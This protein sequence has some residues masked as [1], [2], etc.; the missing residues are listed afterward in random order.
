MGHIVKGVLYQMKNADMKVIAIIL[1]IALLFTLFT[2]NAVS[3]ASVVMLFIGGGTTATDGVA[4]EGTDGIGTSNTGSTVTSNT[5]ST[6]TSNTGSTVTSNT[7]STATN[8]T[9]STATD[10]GGSGSAQQGTDANQGAQQG[11]DAN[12]PVIA[13]PFAF[14]SKAAND[15]HT[16]GIA[17]YNKI[18]W[19]T[20]L[21]IEGLGILDSVIVPILESFMTTEDE[22][23][24]K[25][26]PKG[27]EDAMNRMPASNA[28]AQWIKSATAQKNG[29]N[30][31]VTVVLADAT[32]PSYADT[33]GYPLMTREFLDYK[34]VEKE[35]ANISIVKSLE[36]EI[37]Y[38]D[39]TITAEMTAD[40]KFISITHWGIGYMKA[41]LNG[42]INANGEL[43]FNAKYTDFQ[44]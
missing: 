19:Q 24:V 36:G 37:V 42:S 25:Q 28:S 4:Q 41:N 26:N 16:K 10:N 14:Y 33:D 1:S 38:K 43:E 32:N 13:D 8:N 11:A 20:P 18:S 2:T 40:G 22:A 15:I 34:D 3:V 7:G 29:D 35:A 21:K 5:G 30:Y 17:G 9:G 23:E 31:T 44:Y 12:D 27:S 39:Y 6:V